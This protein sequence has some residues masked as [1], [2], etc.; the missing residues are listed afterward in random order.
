M[1]PASEPSD[2]PTARSLDLDHG[3]RHL[4]AVR[5]WTRDALPGVT[6]DELED[7]L[8]VVTELVSN[9]FDHS[10]GPRQLRLHRSTEPCPVR[11]EIDDASTQVPVLGTS[12]LG[13][14]RGRGLIIVN[15]LAKDWGVTTTPSGKTVWAEVECQHPFRSS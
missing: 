3:A 4:A 7:I 9:A 15:R 5:G 14:T 11:V 2:G 6:T 13:G 8:L 12:R 1:Q 10:R